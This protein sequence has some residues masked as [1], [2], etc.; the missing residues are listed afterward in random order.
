MLAV[1]SEKLAI[2]SLCYLSLTI[3]IDRGQDNIVKTPS[4]NGLCCVFGLMDI[5]GL[6][7][8]A[9]LD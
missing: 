1:T 4:G 5:Q 8:L 7:C 6:G 2:Y 3:T 9:S